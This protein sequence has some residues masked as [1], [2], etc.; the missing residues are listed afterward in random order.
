V[1][2]TTNVNGKTLTDEINNITPPSVFSVTEEECNSLTLR[3]ECPKIIGCTWDLEFSTCIVSLTNKECMTYNGNIDTVS[4]G[5]TEIIR[6]DPQMC[7][8]K[9]CTWNR[10]PVGCES[11]T[12]N[13]EYVPPDVT[14]TVFNKPGKGPGGGYGGDSIIPG[15]DLITDPNAPTPNPPAPLTENELFFDTLIG[16]DATLAQTKV[17][18]QFK[19]TLNVVSRIFICNPQ[20]NGQLRGCTDRLYRNDRVRI[21]VQDDVTNIVTQSPRIE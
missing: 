19:D 11:R 2:A 10:L 3:N 21:Y 9:G 16:M 18:E 12:K 4:G 7:K 8:R 20:D 13:Y 14:A 6:P 15:V 5:E 17:Y 1:T